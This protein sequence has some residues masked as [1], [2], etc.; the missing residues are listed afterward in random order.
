M[1]NV[2]IIWTEQKKI[3]VWNKRQFVENKT[4]YVACLKNAV[5][6]VL[7]KYIEWIFRDVFLR[8]YY[9]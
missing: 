6:F 1:K 2:N 8:A 3:K 5:N 7:P 4:D 9:M